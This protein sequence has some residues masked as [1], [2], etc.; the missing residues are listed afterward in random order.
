L[1]T[2]HTSGRYDARRHL[3]GMI[4][5]VNRVATP[6]R[7]LFLIPCAR[8]RSCSSRVG[9]LIDGLRDAAGAAPNQCDVPPA[10]ASIKA[11]LALVKFPTSSMGFVPKVSPHRTLRWSEM[12]S[13]FQYAGA[14]NLVVAGA[15]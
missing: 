13:N 4:G 7:V 11:A 3:S 2:P 14:A 8:S 10:A 1:L 5:G 12:D 6:S 9:G 15:E